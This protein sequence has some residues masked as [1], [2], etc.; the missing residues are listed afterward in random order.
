MC[1]TLALHGIF[2]MSILTIKG[3]FL[4]IPFTPESNIVADQHIEVDELP[5]TKGIKCKVLYQTYN[6]L[7][8]N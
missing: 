4:A 2:G 5:N 7:D 6:L 8:K 3:I 1:N